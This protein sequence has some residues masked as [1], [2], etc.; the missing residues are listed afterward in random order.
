MCQSCQVPS[1]GSGEGEPVTLFVARLKG[2]SNLCSFQVECSGC[3][4][5]TSYQEAIMAHQLIRALV[6]PEIHERV[7]A[8]HG[9]N[10]TSLNELVK[11]VE[12]QEMG[13]RNQGILADS[14][15]LNRVMDYKSYK[16]TSKVDSRTLIQANTQP[17][18]SNYGSTA[19]SNKVED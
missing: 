6:D 14:G 7:M 2:W 3:K 5:S 12:A 4:K 9:N 19:H 10:D 13:K 1:D 18:C 16:D 17:S 8:E 15:A 11:Y